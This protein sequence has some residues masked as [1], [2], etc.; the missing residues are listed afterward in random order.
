MAVGIAT[1]VSDACGITSL[2]DAGDEAIVVP[3]GDLDALVSA[4]DDLRDEDR[5]QAAA[6]RGL[7]WAQRRSWNHV[8]D[9]LLPS[10]KAALEG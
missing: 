8:V 5:R 4:I 2:F 9:D 6:D 7:V 3:Q 1:V 10:L